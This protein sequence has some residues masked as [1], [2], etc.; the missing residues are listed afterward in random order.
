M[1][2][3]VL[4]TAALPYANGSLHFGHIAGV[5]L[6]ADIFSRFERLQGSDILFICGAD[7]YGVAITLSAELANRS[8][9]EHV[10]YYFGEL[11]KTFSRL[12][13]QFDYF[14]R[15]TDSHHLPFV[16]SFFKDLNSNGHIEIRETEQLYSEGENR[17]LA[18][19]YV[20]GICPRCGFEEARGDEC[21]KCGASFE[22]VDLKNPKSKLTGSP[23]TKRKSHHAY[24]LFE[25]FREKLAHFLESKPWRSNVMHFAKHY[26]DEIRARAITRDLEWGIP[27]PLPEAKGKVFYVWFDAPIG[28]ISATAAWATSIGAS[29]R[30][31]EYW[32]DPKVHYVQF[33]G[34]D[35][36]PFHAL[37]FPAMIMGQNQPYKQVNDLVSSEFYNL[38]G[39]QFSKSEGWTIDLE[40][41]LNRFQL[42]QVRYVLVAT[43]PETGDSDFTWRE[44]QSRCNSELL[45]KFGNFIHRVLVFIQNNTEGKIPLRNDLEE[46]DLKFINEITRLTDEI[47]TRYSEYRFRKAALQ[48]MELAGA[49][50]AYF[51][52]KAPWKDAKDPARRSVMETTLNL[53]LEAIKALAVVSSPIIPDSALKIWHFLGESG[54]IKEW[55]RALEMK[56]EV[57]KKLPSPSPLFLRVEDEMIE[58]EMEKLK[59]W[60]EKAT[61]KKEVSLPLKP[62]VT[63]D[64]FQK[65]DLRV[66]LVLSAEKVPKSKKLLKLQVDL[67]AEERTILSGISEHYTAES[68][69]GKKVIVIA[70]LQPAKIMGIESRGMIL[71][72]SIDKS[73]ELLTVTDLPAGAEIS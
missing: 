12:N 41:V 7:E 21:G 27:V 68:I 61:V 4:V 57:G 24:L 14:S 71:A 67:G 8:P 62:Q 45:G 2:R 17:F 52:L 5:Y 53:C 64:D 35:N 29:D 58:A 34:K 43:A 31:K 33:M 13:I 20:V 16:Q 18:D 46:I 39:R 6:P 36:I 44:F 28:Y 50:N 51:D 9:K 19:R 54:E 63:I 38:E 11:K 10:D 37:F 56:L 60:H 49:G 65:I 69:V 22:A 23:L 30:W 66:G 26:L 59:N 40:E 3:K 55:N 48:V 42:D 70:N 47:K 72:G 1:K 32:L 15:T 73:L 25:N